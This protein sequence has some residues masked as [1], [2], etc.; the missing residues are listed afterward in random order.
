MLERSWDSVRATLE[1]FDLP[2]YLEKAVRWAERH[3]RA[4]AA[5]ALALAMAV[6]LAQAPGETPTEHDAYN[7]ETP[8]FV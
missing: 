2:P 6:L 4:I 3:P 5:G 7:G 8:L 1:K